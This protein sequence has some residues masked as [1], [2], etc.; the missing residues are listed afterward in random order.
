MG[1]GLPEGQIYTVVLFSRYQFNVNPDKFFFYNLPGGFAIAARE[2]NT[3][4]LALEVPS[5]LRSKS[6]NKINFP[7]RVFI[8]KIFKKTR[9]VGKFSHG[10]VKDGIKQ[11]IILDIEGEVDKAHCLAYICPVEYIV[12]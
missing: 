5:A 9:S 11:I 6:R 7:F 2:D 8:D 12:L 10:S 1:R 3:V 4:L